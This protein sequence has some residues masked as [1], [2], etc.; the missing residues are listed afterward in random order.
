MPDWVYCEDTRLRLYCAEYWVHCFSPACGDGNQITGYIGH[1]PPLHSL[2]CM[3]YWMNTISLVFGRFGSI[4]DVL[5][6]AFGAI[7]AA[8]TL[9]LMNLGW[10]GH[11]TT[12][13]C[14]A[15]I[16]DSTIQSLWLTRWSDNGRWCLP[17]GAI[18]PGESTAECCAREVLE[19]TEWSVLADYSV[20]I[21][22]HTASFSTPTGTGDEGSTYFLKRSPLVGN[23]A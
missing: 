2:P 22:V 6:N 15:V 13:T 7:T 10:R 21:R 4:V 3:E 8:P 20:F 18:D 17:G 16:F 11:E 12:P 19:E 1:W 9:W 5:V 23:F 14:D